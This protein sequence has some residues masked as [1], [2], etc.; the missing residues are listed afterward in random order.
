M[1][2]DRRWQY[3]EFQVGGPVILLQGHN[4]NNNSVAITIAPAPSVLFCSL[5]MISKLR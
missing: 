2:E 5:T 4:I 1:E 3:L